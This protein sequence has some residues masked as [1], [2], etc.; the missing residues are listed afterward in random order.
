MR[1]PT[2]NPHPIGTPQWVAHEDA[3]FRE[4]H[5]SGELHHLMTTIAHVGALYDQAGA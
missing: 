3:W 5:T 1:A 2:T 4:L